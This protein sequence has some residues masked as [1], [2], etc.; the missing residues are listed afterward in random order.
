MDHKGYTF[1]IIIVANLIEKCKTIILSI[2]SVLAGYSAMYHKI[3]NIVEQSLANYS[4]CVVYATI[5]R[6]FKIPL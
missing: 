6:V 5:M 4:F 2:S 1:V 3:H